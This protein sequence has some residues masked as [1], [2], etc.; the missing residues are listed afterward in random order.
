MDQAQKVTV[1]LAEYNTLRAEVFT[2][3]ANFVQ[4]MAL[5]VPVITGLIGISF[6]PLLKIPACVIWAVIAFAIVY[7]TVA[8]IWNELNIRRFSQHLRVLEGQ[9]N[10]LAGED[11]LTWETTHGPGS[12]L[13]P[14]RRSRPS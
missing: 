9:I 3:R 11:L 4:A 7:L 14:L 13:L 2:A 6:S 5:M 8:F 10:T 1:L 12:L